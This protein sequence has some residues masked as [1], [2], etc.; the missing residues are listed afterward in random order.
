M[1][2]KRGSAAQP[3]KGTEPSRSAPGAARSGRCASESFVL[4]KSPLPLVLLYCRLQLKRNCALVPRAPIPRGP[5]CAKVLVPR[6]VIPAHWITMTHGI[7]LIWSQGVMA[8]SEDTALALPQLS[9][10]TVHIVSQLIK[11][12]STGHRSHSLALGTFM[13]QSTPDPSASVK[14]SGESVFDYLYYYGS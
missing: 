1:P 6:V 9:S 3:K 8:T 10:F 2:A 12:P 5:R 4:G 13:L 7:H 11:G 14:P